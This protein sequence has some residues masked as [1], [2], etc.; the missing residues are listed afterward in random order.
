[1]KKQY[2]GLL[3]VL[4]LIL[5]VVLSFIIYNEWPILTGKTIILA[6][7][8]IDPFDPF[9]GQYMAITYEI[10]RLNTGG[11]FKEGDS[12][13]VLLQED[14]QGIWR[15]SGVFKSKP[16]G[17]FIRGK[18]IGINNNVI[19]AEYGIEQFFFERHANLPT[20]NITVEVKVASSGR[21]KL[22]QLFQHGQ[23]IKI[24]Y[25]AANSNS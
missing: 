7:Q 6:T 23:P 5:F 3:V 10:S 18:V 20:R 25:E 24:E 1:M 19:R 22:V 17:D 11:E 15:Q 9:M 16:E 4:A 13:Y 21:A 8:P 12:V 2:K 14:T